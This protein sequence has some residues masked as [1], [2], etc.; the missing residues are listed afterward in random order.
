MSWLSGLSATGRA[1]RAARRAGL[2][3][4]Q[5]AERKAQER[6]LLRRG[7]EQEIALIAPG[8]RRAMQL[9]ARVAHDPAHVVSGRERI[10]A[11]IACDA[12]EI[13]ELD[14][15][16]AAHAGDRGAAGGVA[17]REILDH[18]LTK[19]RLEIE[20]V[21]G[22]AKTLGDAA[23]IVD[24]LAGAAGALPAERRAVVVQ[25]KRD[26]DH[27]AAGLDQERRRA[28]AVDAARHGDDHAALGGRTREL[29][30][31]DHGLTDV[32]F[33]AIDHAAEHGAC[34]HFRQPMGHRRGVPRPSAD[35]IARAA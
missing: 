7:R 34:R 14:A 15:L 10:R 19:P 12:Q 9:D 21:V 26:A 32:S 23:R 13:G 33:L 6:E 8:I 18:R 28:R 27:L 4:V 22:D 31:L 20:H 5:R 1:K 29:Q 24:V 30:V 3:L 17:R 11:E 35:P 16:I 25:L 2:G